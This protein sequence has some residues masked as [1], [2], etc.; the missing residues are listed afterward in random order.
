[1]PA[2]I[3]RARNHPDRDKLW[4]N[5]TRQT[6]A[7]RMLLENWLQR[8]KLSDKSTGIQRELE[9]GQARQLTPWERGRNL[10]RQEIA[11]RRR[12]LDLSNREWL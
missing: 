7:A 10:L 11:C 12:Q 2:S 4:P 9:I 6:E 3:V 1:M 5:V 8:G